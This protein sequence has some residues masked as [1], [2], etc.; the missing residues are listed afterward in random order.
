MVLDTEKIVTSLLCFFFAPLF[1]FLPDLF[2]LMIRD[3]NEREGGR[4]IPSP[5]PPLFAMG[6]CFEPVAT[7]RFWVS[8]CEA[9]GDQLSVIGFFFSC[10][11][12]NIE[13]FDALSVSCWRQ[14]CP[15]PGGLAFPGQKNAIAIANSD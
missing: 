12:N 2:S 6:Q 7:V 4:G 5:L 11:T 14:V 3:S 8:A 15:R 13:S 1:L 10:S 9:F